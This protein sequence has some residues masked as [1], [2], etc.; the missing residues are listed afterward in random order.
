MVENLFPELVPYN[1]TE[2]YGACQR[3]TLKNVTL[4]YTQGLC[5]KKL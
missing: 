3:N 5:S 2:L 4:R 1:L